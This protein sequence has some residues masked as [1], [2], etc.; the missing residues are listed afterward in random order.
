MIFERLYSD[1]VFDGSR[2][3]VLVQMNALKVHISKVRQLR[4]PIRF[5]D[6]GG[7]GAG[8][9]LMSLLGS[10]LWACVWLDVSKDAAG[11]L[12][13]QLAGRLAAAVKVQAATQQ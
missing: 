2:A 11:W 7:I 4:A 3:T 9:L 6:H 12:G 13:G 10:W 8:C 5:S 1:Y